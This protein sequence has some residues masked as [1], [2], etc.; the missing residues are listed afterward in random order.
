VDI[1]I[2][3]GLLAWGLLEALLVSESGPRGAR[4]LLAAGFALPMVVRRRWPIAALAAVSLLMIARSVTFEGLEDEAMPFAVLL[5]GSF[6]AALHAR[7]RAWALTAVPMTVAAI[8]VSVLREDLSSPPAVD[9]AILSTLAV[10]SW[11]AGLVVRRR[12]EQ[13]TLARAQTPGL[14]RQAVAAERDRIAGELHDIVA[15]RVSIVSVQAGAAG[16][17]LEDD[18]A[19]AREHLRAVQRAAH[20]ALGEMRRLL[21]VLREEPAA[22]APQ[23]GLARL[24][25]LVDEAR[26]SGLPVELRE[27]G[28]RGEVPQGV[29][30]AAF[31][32]VQEALAN[33]RRHAG[34]VPTVVRVRYGSD[35]VGLSVENAAGAAGNG[36]GAGH[37]LIGMREWARVFGGT[38]D[39]G[40][41]GRGG[42]AVRARLPR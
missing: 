20:E 15:H 12:A 22:Y 41:D 3:A 8:V 39:A 36:G 1:A 35:D 2:V 40:P 6:S 31:R 27:E 14:V 18:P 4:V 11:T 38:I 32:I 17:L 34:P 25:Q 7:S 37:G 33:V 28:E 21:G 19:A 13:L 5:L 26:S 23:P 42:F 29:D 24:P 30:L 16:Q 10:A 9:I